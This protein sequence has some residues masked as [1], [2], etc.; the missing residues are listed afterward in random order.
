MS[1]QIFQ[2][3]V[4][5]ITGSGAGMGK[6]HA[7]L[8]AS[9]GAAV[10]VNDLAPSAQDVVD[11]IVAAGGKATLSKHDVSDPEQAKALVQT[12]IDTFGGLH[13]V[14]SNAAIIRNVRFIDMDYAGFDQVMK[15]NAYGAFNVLNAAWPH[16]VAQQYGRV[17]MVSSSSAWMSQP[18]IGHYAA[19]KGA[20]L[21]LAKTLSAEGEEFGITV[22]VLAP[23]AFTQLAASLDD[24]EDKRKVMETMMHA[25]LVAPVL[26]WLVRKENTLNGQIIE[27]AAGRAALNF[28][29]STKG[30]WSKDLTVEDLIA[31]GDKVLDQ[32]GFAAIGST[33]ELAEWMTNTNTGWA[34]ELSKA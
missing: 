22:N 14:V 31:N 17:V 5:I 19:S 25:S 30:Y 18:E 7:L 9:R 26:A 12:A 10:V 33:A 32:D 23:G 11:E 1:D 4:A 16:L 8:L 2:G 27:T 34:E 3:E 21:G 28:I 29:G 20:V 15:V 13:I 24:P 6:E